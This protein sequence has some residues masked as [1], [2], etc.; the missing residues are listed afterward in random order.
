ME[1]GGRKLRA[2]VKELLSRIKEGVATKEIDHWAEELIRAKGGE[3]SFKKVSGYHWSICSS[4][5]EQVVH[6]PPSNRVLHQGDIF[7][8]DIGMFYQGF[9]T[10]FATT[11]IIGKAK[12]PKHEAFLSVGKQTLTK[13]LVVVKKDNYIGH[14]S[15]VIEQEITKQGYFIMKQLTGHGIGRDLHEEPAV[16][17]FIDKAIEK[18]YR[19]RP[20]LVI[21]VEVI[22][23]MGTEEIIYEKDEPWSIATKDGSLSACF[24]HTIAVTD[25]N[26]IILT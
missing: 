9:H 20:G 15:Q 14:V 4:V 13:A 23:S 24:E 26:T 21:A 22:Y 11:W 2:V 10:D 3:S 18:T 8:L 25:T 12:D 1:E 7:T 16:L 5:N 6:T 19:I 17:G